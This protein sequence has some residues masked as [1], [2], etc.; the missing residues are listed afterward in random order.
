[1]IKAYLGDIDGAHDAFQHSISGQSELNLTPLAIATSGLIDIRSG[2]VEKGIARYL[3]AAEKANRENDPI[4]ALRAYSFG[5]REVSRIDP[6]MQ[7]LSSS[8]FEKSI[9]E[10]E[11][12]NITVPYDVR[13]LKS[14]IDRIQIEAPERSIDALVGLELADR[15]LN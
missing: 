5:G 8:Q 1:V 13:L 15:L 3:E 6:E 10:F 11:K 4:T 14:E 2:N 12:N 9:S 7:K